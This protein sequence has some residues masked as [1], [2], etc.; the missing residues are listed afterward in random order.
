M[1]KITQAYLILIRNQP[2]DKK[3]RKC[4]VTKHNNCL[5]FDGE[6]V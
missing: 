6:L 3:L 2:I 1:R 5:H 4:S